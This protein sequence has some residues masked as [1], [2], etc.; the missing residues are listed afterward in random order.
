MIQTTVDRV[1]LRL[2]VR[3]AYSTADEDRRRRR[4]ALWISE[5]LVVDFEYVERIE[6][7][8]NGKYQRIVSTLAQPP[9]ESSA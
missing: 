9:G 2:A 3:E 5:S 6:P 7:A 1:T 8:P 4:V